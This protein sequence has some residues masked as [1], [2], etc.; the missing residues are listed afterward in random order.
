[1]ESNEQTNGTN[2]LHVFNETDEQFNETNEQ[3][4]E[5]NEQKKKTKLTNKTAKLTNKLERFSTNAFLI[6]AFRS[7][8]FLRWC[9][10]P[11]RNLTHNLFFYFQ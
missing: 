7:A 8:D 3:N 6:C 9:L 11:K 5:T 1:M 2:E 4:N 10:F